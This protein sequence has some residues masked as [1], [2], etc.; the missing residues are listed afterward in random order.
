MQVESC[1][2]VAK[3]LNRG[4]LSFFITISRVSWPV[5]AP[6]TS[7]PNGDPSLISHTEAPSIPTKGFS[8]QNPIIAF[9]SLKSFGFWAFFILYTYFE[10]LGSAPFAFSSQYF[11]KT[12]IRFACNLSVPE[13]YAAVIWMF[14][15]YWLRYQ[16]RAAYKERIWLYP[17]I[18]EMAVIRSGG[19]EEYCSTGFWLIGW[20]GFSFAYLSVVVVSIWAWNAKASSGSYG[21]GSS[22]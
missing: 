13:G 6:K 5:S 11:F 7:F 16:P 2:W 14:V 17:G 8:G 21:F 12:S 1:E 15:R 22:T 3:R 10:G 9:L 20:T 4:C 19:F 18:F